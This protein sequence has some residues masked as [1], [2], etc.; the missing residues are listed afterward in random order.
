MYTKTNM[1]IGTTQ[2]QMRC[3]STRH[4]SNRGSPRPHG[5]NNKWVSRDPEE[6]RL[7]EGTHKQCTSE[8]EDN[9]K[10]ARSQAK[11]VNSPFLLIGI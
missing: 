9:G 7:L 5:N 2:S 4:S 10:L 11:L 8:A 1:K 6:T 3:M